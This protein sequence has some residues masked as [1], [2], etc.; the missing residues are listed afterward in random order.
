MIPGRFAAA[1]GRGAPLAEGLGAD[2]AMTK[3]CELRKVH[4]ILPYFCVHGYDVASR[5]LQKVDMTLPPRKY[6][7]CNISYPF[8]ACTDMTRLPRKYRRFMIFFCVHGDD[9]TSQ[10]VQKIHDILLRAMI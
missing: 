2:Y 1:E 6:R 8:Y 5:E 4:D 9:V 10:E 7:R 3:I